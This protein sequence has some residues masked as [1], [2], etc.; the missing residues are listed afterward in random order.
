MSSRVGEKK[1]GMLTYSTILAWR[2][3]LS[4]KPRRLQFMGLQRVRHNRATNTTPEC[5]PLL[6]ASLLQTELLKE[7]MMKEE[8]ASD[9]LI[10]QVAKGRARVAGNTRNQ[11]FPPQRQDSNSNKE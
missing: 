8:N 9:P 2:I 1:K 10:K 11:S 6:Q 5:M 3:L 4:E 7:H